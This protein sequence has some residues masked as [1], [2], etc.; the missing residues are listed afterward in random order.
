MQMIC[1]DILFILPED[2]QV[3]CIG[4]IFLF[5]GQKTDTNVALSAFELLWNIIPVAKTAEIWISVFQCHL[6]LIR[7]EIS[8]ISLCA[9][10]TLF[11]LIVSHWPSLPNEVFDYL[12]S[13]CFVQIVDYLEHPAQAS[14]LTQQYAFNELAHCGQTLPKAFTD[15]L[16]ERLIDLQNKFMMTCQNRDALVA[17]FQFFEEAFRVSES[18]RLR[19]YEK[20]NILADFLIQTE[21]PQSALFGSMGRMIRFILPNHKDLLSDE[22]LERWIQLIEKL[23]VQL[24]THHFLPPTTHKSLDALSLLFPLPPTQVEMIYRLLVGL[25]CNS[26]RNTRLTEV[27]LQHICS[28]C[29]EKIG[30]ELVPKLFILSTKLFTL[31]PARRLLL[32][33]VEKDMVIRDE[34]VETVGNMLLE[35]GQ[36]EP[37]LLIKTGASL[38]KLFLRMSD[39][40]KSQVVDAHAACRETQECL[41]TLYLDPTSST[42]D[43]HAAM[44]FSRQVVMSFGKFLSEANDDFLE[45]I[46]VFLKQR[47]T[48]GKAFEDSRTGEYRHLTA[49]L[50]VFADLVLHPSE[51]V[52]KLLRE[53]F[54]LL[55]DE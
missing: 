41:W 20:M 31:K 3:K 9:V 7:D 11:A 15:E 26:E 23:I 27:A 16:W 35:L 53:I 29:E 14:E 10:K 24:S 4:I 39:A 28:I 2:D 6:A 49:L 43:E 13:D 48:L 54:L 36:S 50:P 45:T 46:L 47:K 40:Q 32:F 37:E 25:A 55:V 21:P 34:V 1:N 22:W 42:F 12:G 19:L 18:V 17:S 44:L 5:A 8:D 33:F 30:D 52:R 38:L 51:D